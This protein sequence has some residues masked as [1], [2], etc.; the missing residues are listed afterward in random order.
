MKKLNVLAIDIGHNVRF[1]SGACGLRLEDELNR[2]VGESL[3]RKCTAAGIE[4]INCLPQA[5]TSLA[6][7]LSRRVYVANKANADF[8]ISIHHNATPGGYGSE[9]YCIKGGQQ[10]G[11]SE[12]CAITILNEICSL[13]YRNRG[14]KDTRKLYVINQTIM[15]AILIECAFVDSPSDMNGYNPEK[16]AEAI[17]KGIIKSFD[18]G[19]GIIEPTTPSS[20]NT[21]S[22]T[23]SPYHIV[24]SGDTLW[25]I[26]RKYGIS[27]D[28]LVEVNGIKN[29]NLIN[30]GQKIRLS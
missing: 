7:S 14:V 16:V 4:V 17:Y 20:S 30:I 15:P 27:V 6:D 19:S 22:V 8:F 24:S 9:I 5:S 2:L 18:I 12:K 13:G 11:L 29:R 26:S 23:S 3:I 28:R 25:G 21:S 10:N 1:D